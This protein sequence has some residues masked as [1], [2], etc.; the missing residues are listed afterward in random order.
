MSPSQQQPSILSFFP[1]AQQQKQPKYAPPPSQTQTR[2]QTVTA[3][4]T[5]QLPPPAPAAP[6]IP[7]PARHAAGPAPASALPPFQPSPSPHPSASIAPL[8]EAH[9]PALRRINSLLLPVAYADSFYAA[10]IDPSASGLLSRAILWADPAPEDGRPAPA[11][12][13]VVGGLV[14]RL[15]PSPF[16]PQSG[17]YSPEQHSP[18]AAQPPQ[19]YAV[20]IQSLALLA[21]F[22]GLGLAAAAVESVVSAAAALDGVDAVYAHVWTENDEGLR[23]YAARGFVRDR[24][25]RGYY[26]K[27][28]PDAAWIVRRPVRAARA[29]TAATPVPTPP[30]VTGIGAVPHGGIVGNSTMAAA[31]NLPGFAQAA[32]PV[33]APVTEAAVPPPAANSTR[34]PVT[35]SPAPSLSFQNKRAETEWND[36]P[37]EMVASSRSSSRSNLLAPSGGNGTGS[38]ASSRS[39][40]AAPRKK[41]DRAY[42][43]AAFG[44]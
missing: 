24:L 42:P 39:S 16:D 28:R 1:P 25:V 33:T 32:S 38:G 9:I 41:R 10:A 6:P 44:K 19:R 23:W 35:P 3:V 20:Y 26:F 8:V 37:E 7:P 15:E 14:C 30:L 22:R 13:K 43:A 21:P 27:L 17:Q 29:S 18:A 34:P 31:V 12:P 2:Q 11:E 5:G 40:S 4:Y 36:L